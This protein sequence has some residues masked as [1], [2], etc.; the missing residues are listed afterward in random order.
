MRILLSEE[1]ITDSDSVGKTVGA[2]ASVVVIELLSCLP[3]EKEPNNELKTAPANLP[4]VT[5]L[6]GEISNQ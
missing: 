1:S 2:G 6:L 4:S 3:V 5:V